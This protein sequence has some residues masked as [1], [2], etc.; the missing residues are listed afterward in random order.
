MESL[1]DQPRITYAEILEEMLHASHQANESLTGNCQKDVVLA[2]ICQKSGLDQTVIPTSNLTE[3]KQCVAKFLSRF[4]Q[5]YNSPKV[6]RKLDRILAD[7]WAHSVL[8]LPDTFISLL[9]QK[10]NTNTGNEEKQA[11]KEPATE[12]QKGAVGRKR[13]LF[14]EKTTRSQLKESSELRGKFSPGVIHLASK[15]NLKIQGKNDAAFVVKRISSETGSTA[16]FARAAILARNNFSERPLTK[17][18]PEEA[19]FFL[20][21]N[22]LTKEQYT[23]MKQACR[24]SG[25]DIWPAYSYVQSAKLGLEPEQISIEENQAVAPL[26][27]VL[28]HTV[29]RLIHSNPEVLQKME[30]IAENNDNSLET[31]LYYKIGFDSSGA[32]TVSQQTNSEGEHRETKS[33][34]ASQMAPI[35]LVAFID[36]E[37][38]CLLDY[39]GQNSP[40]SCRPL[41]LSFE[42]ENS[43]TMQIEY[44]RLQKEIDQLQNYLISENPRI[45]VTF[46]G[47]FTLIDG[48]VLCSITG[49]KTT[50]CPLCHKSGKELAKNE[51]PF[52]VESAKFLEYGASPLHFGLR[53]FSVLLQIGYKQD[54]RQHRVTKEHSAKFE[55][56][57]LIVK[58]A[59]KTEL[60]LIVD[61]GSDPGKTLSGNVARKAF[62]NPIVFAE[63]IGV[64]PMLV[65]NLDIIWRTMA[66]NYQI[67][68][69]EFEEFCKQTL[70]IYLSE[71]GWYNIPPT[72]H[73][74]LVHGRAIVD[75]CPV[76]L[77]LTSEESSE[78]NNKFIRKFLL[79]HTRKTSHLDTMT[80]LFHRLMAVSDPCLLS[81]SLKKNKKK[82]RQ[83]TPEMKEL[84]QIPESDICDSSSDDKEIESETE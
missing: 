55:A 63:I 54:F 26:Q 74:V 84:L 77:G 29:K 50:E 7:K 51:G 80:D 71:V 47:L 17:K 39:P 13:K 46:S 78:A 3:L 42:K 58:K 31:T 11:S 82:S 21:T 81:K 22:N 25:A 49:A 83:F 24:E 57:K 20:L 15:Q 59:F 30:D 48:K 56:R 62:A 45:S 37:E 28:N 19:L 2:F 72:I 16:K 67:N 43:E 41:R 69:R 40:H 10:T 33:L 79:Q 23:N 44:Q 73:K 64:S 65:S 32:H 36:D 68:S 66:S 8:K 75:A 12:K 6:S 76:A 70:D 61:S 38:V 5:R 60:N 9:V 1:N 4:T 18:T 52:E 53:A 35:K 27:D 34:M 14:E